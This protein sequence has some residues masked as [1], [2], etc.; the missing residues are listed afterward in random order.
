[1]ISIVIVN[2]NSGRL[3]EDC[4]QSL[5]ANAAGCQIVIVDNASL[6]S[7]LHFLAG[8]GSDISVLQNSRNIG[9][10]AGNNLGWRASKGEH[11]LFLNPDTECLRGSVDVLTRTLAVDK[12]VWAAGGQL[13]SPSGQSQHGFNVRSFPTV[14]EWLRIC[15]FWTK[16]GLQSHGSVPICWLM[17]LFRWMWINP[18][19]R[20]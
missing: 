17:A 12:T 5:I 9:F 20:A 14:M 1:V 8:M 19:A 16:S 2:W 3:L 13:L 11:I 10:A 18:Q 4:I 6:D 15:C 7:S